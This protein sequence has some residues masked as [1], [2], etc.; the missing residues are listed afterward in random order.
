MGDDR[1]E[2]SESGQRVII[3]N[4][5]LIHVGARVERLAILRRVRYMIFKD[6]YIIQPGLRELERWLVARQEKYQRKLRRSK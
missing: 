4:E 1:K 6:Q 2:Q 5:L 3:D